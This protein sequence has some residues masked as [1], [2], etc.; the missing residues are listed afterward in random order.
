MPLI[1]P[2]AIGDNAT[3]RF[4]SALAAEEAA[5][6]IRVAVTSLD[7]DDSGS[8]TCSAEMLIQITG[9]AS[10]SLTR[11][12]AEIKK[13]ERT[14]GRWQI[15]ISVVIRFCETLSDNISFAFT[16]LTFL[17]SSG[18]KCE[19]FLQSFARGCTKF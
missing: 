13:Y 14:Q 18:S 6:M 4:I 1:Y 16:T 5:D 11:L 7:D 15:I 9:N 2:A 17:C 12:E 3:T 8:R 10:D 19:N